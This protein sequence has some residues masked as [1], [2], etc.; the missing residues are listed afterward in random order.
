MT[1]R[2][3]VAVL[4]AT[5]VVGQ[6]LVQRLV[7][8][9]LFELTAVGASERSVARRFGEALHRNAG[10]LSPET[11]DL[12]VSA[13]HPSMI[14]A[15]IVFSALDGTVAGPIEEAF[16]RAGALVVSNA[17]HHRLDDDV[18]LVIP[19][20]N[21]D[22]LELIERQRTA[23]RWSGAIVTNPNCATAVICLALAPLHQAFGLRE[24]WVTTLQ[25]VSGAGYPGV[26]SLDIL[27]NVIPW[28]DGEEE[29]IVME[30]RKILGDAAHPTEFGVSAQVTRV[31]VEHG[32]TACIAARFARPVTAAEATSALLEWRSAVADLGLPSAPATPVMLHSDRDRPQP[33]RDVERGDGMSVSVGQV[34]EDG[35]GGIRLVALGHN[36]VRGAAGA[37]L[38]NAELCVSALPAL[39][40]PA[41]IPASE[42]RWPSG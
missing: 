29:K 6:T 14:D 23:R 3:P 25:A 26:P 33:R 34:R 27:G 11:R 36:L 42:E 5:G 1:S 18:P 38:L 41:K 39:A 8:H 4:G 40:S 17:K 19:E 9:P 15:P 32:H 22:H 10:D 7:D 31:P 12:V 24:L 30:S 35:N 2:I 13:C 20:V 16:A 37:A 21:A 28:I